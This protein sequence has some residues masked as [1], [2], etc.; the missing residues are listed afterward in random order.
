[1]KTLSNYREIDKTIQE[2]RD[3]SGDKR[4]PS[5]AHLLHYILMHDS[6][7]R[8]KDICRYFGH[9][10]SDDS[11]PVRERLELLEKAGLLTLKQKD[12]YRIPSDHVFAEGVVAVDPKGEGSVMTSSEGHQNTVP[13]TRPQTRRVID[14][15]RVL[16]D[17]LRHTDEF[18][19][20]KVGDLVG[21]LWL[22]GGRMRAHIVSERPSHAANVALVRAILEQHRRQRSRQIDIRRIM[23]YLPHR[24]PLLLVDRILEFESRR[25]IVGLKNVTI[26]E[27]FFGGHFPEHPVMPGVLVIEAMAQVGGLLLMDTVS[28]PKDKVVYFM[29]LNN[30]KWRRPVVPGD[31][32]IFELELTRFRRA[33][34]RM[35]GRG[36]VDG[37][38]VAEAE[39]T[40]RIVDR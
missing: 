5:P 29:S 4:Y 39:M 19:R 14:G 17:S 10:E 9:A 26:N 38:V 11:L 37:Q 30:V 34:C 6:T 40:A 32:L 31:Q 22:A 27:P 35:K 2:F 25:R 8:F 20:H 23:H 21:D 16:N 3:F 33:T 13:L 18:L 24:Y 1:M 28:N 15:D 36:M 12:V 7:R